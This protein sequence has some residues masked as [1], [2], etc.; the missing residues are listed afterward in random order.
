MEVKKDI[1]QSLQILNVT[2]SNFLKIIN[3]YDIRAL[4]HIPDG[5]NNNI[6]WN[7]GH[8]IATQQLLTYGLSGLSTPMSK[9]LI[10]QYRKGTKPE[11][12]KSQAELDELINLSESLITQF[13][14]DYSNGLFKEYNPY[15]TSYGIEL[16]SVDLAIE[17]NNVHEGMHLGTCID[18]KR[19]LN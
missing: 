7:F 16:T 14:E 18:I 5:F 8:I 1:S 6:I 19:F 12:D 11:S 15:T 9:D 17:F 4:N 2:R 3:A 10:N 13:K